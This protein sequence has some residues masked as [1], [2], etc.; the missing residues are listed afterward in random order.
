MRELD[1]VTVR[2]ASRQCRTG[3]RCSDVGVLCGI[4]AAARPLSATGHHGYPF[5]FYSKLNN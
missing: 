3:N 4:N 5:K 2:W 1:D